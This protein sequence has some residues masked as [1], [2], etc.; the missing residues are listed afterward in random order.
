MRRASAL[1]LV[2]LLV[3]A[4]VVAADSFPLPGTA[5]AQVGDGWR[6]LANVHDRTRAMAFRVRAA[7]D[8]PGYSAMWHEL[9]PAATHSMLIGSARPPVN[10]DSEIVVLFG[11]GIGSCTVGVHLIDVVIDRSTRLVHSVT[12]Q[13]R[14]CLHLDLTGSVVFVV[15]LARGALPLAPFTIQ[16]RAEPTCRSCTEHEDRLTL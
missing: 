4:G 13:R 5:H 16:L 3:G 9:G 14:N 2:I 11:V 6:L 15:A 12:T 10:F 8:N 7:T 1:A